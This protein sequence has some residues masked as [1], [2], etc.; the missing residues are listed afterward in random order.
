MSI[1]F[2]VQVRVFE[3][4]RHSYDQQVHF[5]LN[6]VVEPIAASQRMVEEFA[7]GYHGMK[8]PTPADLTN[9]T[10]NELFHLLRD[11]GQSDERR[12]LFVSGSLLRLCALPEQAQ[13]FSGLGRHPHEGERVLLTIQ[14]ENLPNERARHSASVVSLDAA[15]MATV[16]TA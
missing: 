16:G 6:D 7:R 11:T 9:V 13:S 3:D 8:D 5:Q 1:R 14:R 2:D 4:G 12:T 10:C 15:N